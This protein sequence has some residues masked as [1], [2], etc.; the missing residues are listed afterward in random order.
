MLKLRCPLKSWLLAR[1]HEDA[2]DVGAWSW[3]VE[4]IKRCRHKIQALILYLYYLLIE[5]VLY[6]PHDAPFNSQTTCLSIFLWYSF[7]I[8]GYIHVRLST[9]R[10]CIKKPLPAVSQVGSGRC[11][12]MAAAEKKWLYMYIVLWKSVFEAPVNV[13]WQVPPQG[14]QGA[15]RF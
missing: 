12:S 7:D 5:F 1:C 2:G 10:V 11:W 15:P 4:I 13:Y 6:D 3:R 14:A 9:N 8:H